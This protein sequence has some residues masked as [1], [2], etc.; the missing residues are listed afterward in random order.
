MEGARRLGYTFTT[1]TPRT[2]T[3]E[4]HGQLLQFD[5]L[6]VLEFTSTRKRMSVSDGVRRKKDRGRRGGEKCVD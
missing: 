3:V 2:V 1:R 4:S 6:N 5:V